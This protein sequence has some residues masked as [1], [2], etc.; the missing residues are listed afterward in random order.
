MKKKQQS[1]LIY[2]LPVLALIG[3]FAGQFIK[4]QMHFN[5]SS[6]IEE[7]VFPIVRENISD[8]MKLVIE[9]D[10]VAIHEGTIIVYLKQDTNAPSSPEAT[11]SRDFVKSYLTSKL[12]SWKDSS[13]YQDKEIEVRF[14]DE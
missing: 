9:P 10:S 2:I 12:R 11:N 5:E 4:K 14:T 1:K 13:A 3:Y 6:Q 7:E 8:D